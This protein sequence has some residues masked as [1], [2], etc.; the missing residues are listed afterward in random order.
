[1]CRQWQ[2]K[3]IGKFYFTVLQHAAGKSFAAAR[4]SAVLDNLIGK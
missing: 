2:H 3:S 1:M 4:L